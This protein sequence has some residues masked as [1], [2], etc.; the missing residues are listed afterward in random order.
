MAIKISVITFILSLVI[1]SGPV[2]AA[3]QPVLYFNPDVVETNPGENNHVLLMMDNADHGLSGYG[4]VISVNDPAIASVSSAS[5]PAWAGVVDVRQIDKS[6][7][8]IQATDIS[9]SLIPGSGT[10]VLA[11]LII[12]AGS[13]GYGYLT[14][15][16][17]AID[18]DM[19]GRYSPDI[20]PGSI[21]IAGAG[22]VPIIP[23]STET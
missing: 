14:A 9:D 21:I 16:P 17:I 19:K 20:I 7:V 2:L 13:P 1:L 18:D 5:V 8:I 22:P 12:H 4:I 15:T 10:I 23:M 6:S 3:M 11:D